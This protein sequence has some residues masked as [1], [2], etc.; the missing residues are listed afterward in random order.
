MTTKPHRTHSSTKFDSPNPA[1]TSRKVPNSLPSMKAPY[2][3]QVCDRILSYTR[4]GTI[5]FIFCLAA[6]AMAQLPPSFDDTD[7]TVPPAALPGAPDLY[8]VPYPRINRT[9][10]TA[11]EIEIGS[12]Y[13][14]VSYSGSQIRKA[15]ALKEKYPRTM[16]LRY[17]PGAYQPDNEGDGGQRSFLST[18]P[19][20]V[21]SAVFAGHWLYLAGSRLKTSVDSQALVLTVDDSSR[22]TAGQDIVIYN[23]GPGVFLEA[24]HARITS[25]NYTNGTL[26]LA[27]RGF[28]STPTSHSAGAVVAQHELGAGGTDR[29]RSPEHW[30]YNLGTRCPLDANGKQ[31]NVVMAEWLAEN[32]NL[33]RNGN[34]IG[35]FEYDGVLFDGERGYFLTD[36]LADMDNDL[37]AEG[38]L[39][40]STGENMHGPGSEALYARL[41]SLIPANKILV[42]SGGNIRGYADLNG[43]QCEGYPNFGSSYFSPPEYSLRDQKLASYAYHLHHHAYGPVYTEIISKTPTLLYPHLDNGGSPPTSNSSFRYSFGMALLEDGSYGQKRPGVHDPWWDEFSVDVTPGSA[44]FGQAIPNDETDASQIAKVR[45]HT[46]WLGSPLGRRT[47]VFNPTGF[48][49]AKTLLPNSGFES[50]LGGWAGHNVGVSLQKGASVFSGSYSL[51]SSAVLTYL[52]DIYSA[53][54]TSPPVYLAAAKTYTVCFAVRAS[55]QREFGVQFGSGAMQT[56]VSDTGWKSHVLTFSANA[57]ENALSFYFGRESSDI[58]LDEIYLFKGN[59]NGFRR[60][61]QNGTVFVNATS[62][63]RKVRPNGTFRRI[64]GTQDPINDGSL[65]GSELV[66]PAYDAAI[67]V[68]VP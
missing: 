28:K 12:K 67:L 52:P 22:F 41:R 30:S 50:G 45:A 37:I 57:G 17:F 55:S 4:L 5:V 64:K 43:T 21:G 19:A 29:T 9:E 23:G 6:T 46:G 54:V 20:S 68:R 2:K 60:D 13:N 36:L 33:D 62:V 18:G 10:G 51:H 31:M 24:E 34:R 56:I 61:F 47:R 1:L 66:I 65:V 39:N 59:P 42:G 63:P 58:W 8:S 40:P 14:T 25:I 16:V 35:S 53:S 15:A 27:A 48:D 26:T 49:I 38:G 11:P 3:L 32:L 7:W 44:T